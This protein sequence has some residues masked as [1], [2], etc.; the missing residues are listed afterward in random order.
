MTGMNP[1]LNPLLLAL[2]EQQECTRRLLVVVHR[3]LPLVPPQH[4]EE[5]QEL[6]DEVCAS[7]RDP[8]SGKTS[9]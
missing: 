5:A 3:I 7:L 6:L 9:R 1:F 8:L 2:R 4:A